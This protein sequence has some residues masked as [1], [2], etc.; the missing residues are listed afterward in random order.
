MRIN[1]EYDLTKAGIIKKL[2]ALVDSELSKP[3]EEIDLSLVDES[4]NFLMELREEKG[5]TDEEVSAKVEAIPFVGKK[6]SSESQK[7]KKFR[8]RKALPIAAVLIII[9]ATLCSI[10]ASSF[11]TSASD[12]L[13]R[14]GHSI[15]EIFNGEKRE[16]NE[17]TIVK[18]DSEEEYGKIENLLDKEHIHILYPTYLPEGS[19]IEK[20]FLVEADGKSEILFEISGI[21]SYGIVLDCEIPEEEESVYKE[22]ETVNGVTVLITYSPDGVQA[23]FEHNG[24]KYT[25]CDDDYGDL[26]RIIENLEEVKCNEN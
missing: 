8:I 21:V 10:V 14:I 11:G 1:N 26:I 17:I 20:I 15:V 25:V 3:Y 22:K 24:N 23:V 5:L 18:P 19:S 16:V 2:E 13:R 12:V 7:K 4:V 6:T 9:I